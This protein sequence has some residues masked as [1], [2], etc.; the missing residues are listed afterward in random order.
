M[1]LWAADGIATPVRAPAPPSGKK[2]KRKPTVPPAGPPRKPDVELIR[3]NRARLYKAVDAFA[4]ICLVHGFWPV[5][6]QLAAA[7]YA[8]HCGIHLQAILLG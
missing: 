7:C 8:A 1:A 4:T 5:L 3:L 2:Q 6:A